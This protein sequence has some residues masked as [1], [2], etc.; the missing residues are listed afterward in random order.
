[1]QNPIN[2]VSVLVSRSILLAILIIGHFALDVSAQSIGRIERER[3]L[4]ML[5][6]VR[7]DLEKHYYDPQ[8]R[9]L[10]L[11]SLF[12][13]AEGRIRTAATNLD[14]IG[15]IAEV[16]FELEDSHTFFVPPGLTVQ[17][18]YGWEMQF[19]GDSCFVTEVHPWSDA[20]K[21]GLAPGDL[22]VSV[23][24]N[25]PSRENLWKLMYAYHLLRPQKGLRVVVSSPGSA[26]RQ[27]DLEARVRQRS[28]VLDL[29]GS[30]GGRDIWQLILEAENEA[31][32]HRSLYIKADG[33]LLI[34]RLPEFTPD[35]VSDG[36]KQLRGRSGVI[37]DLRGN[38]GGDEKALLDLLGR[39]FSA[40]VNVGTL[41]RRSGKTPLTAKGKV[42]G[43]FLGDLIVLVDSRS[44]SASEVLARTV[45]LTDRGRVIGDRTAGAVMR[46]RGEGHAM[47]GQVVILYSTSVT[48]ADVIFPDGSRLEKQGVIPDLLLL[49]TSADLAAGRDPV[50]SHAAELLGVKIA[51]EKAWSL[52]RE[53]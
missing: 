21:Q 37:L 45:Q 32:R 24:G 15:A 39:F 53:K 10:D 48:D 8:Y 29:T 9:G 50:L 18:N 2:V 27:L 7:K 14:V 42:D 31:D 12:N 30:D 11:D 5:R 35:L 25:H 23:N 19:V 16:L 40:D 52:L 38:A 13:A 17:V 46:S 3:G 1:M 36:V 47:G 33:N 51:P 22:I 49:P 41:W 6:Q 28:R 26:P 34:W 44:G 20:R 4:T 43:A